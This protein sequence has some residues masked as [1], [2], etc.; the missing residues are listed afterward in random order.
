MK[1]Y[2]VGEHNQE[3]IGEIV[4]GHIRSAS[5][6]RIVGVPIVPFGGPDAI[7]SRRLVPCR[8]ASGSK[9]KNQF[10]DSVF[11]TCSNE[12]LTEYFSFFSQIVG[13]I[14]TYMFILLNY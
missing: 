3:G 10:K 14:I 2:I 8:N 12:L 6:V 1:V 9:R 11:L 7:L 5:P 13:A 4:S